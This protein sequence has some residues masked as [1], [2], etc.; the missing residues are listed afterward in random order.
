MAAT[1]SVRFRDGLD[2]TV[3]G[4]SMFCNSSRCSYPSIRISASLKSRNRPA[5][6]EMNTLKAGKMKDSGSPF[7]EMTPEEREY[8]E[9]MLEDVPPSLGLPMDWDDANSATQIYDNQDHHGQQPARFVWARGANPA[10]LTVEY[11]VPDEHGRWE[12]ATVERCQK[13]PSEKNAAP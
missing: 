1:V 6:V 3:I 2:S 10:E 9:G 4:M 8:F 11:V 12:S 5:G 7:R 13:V